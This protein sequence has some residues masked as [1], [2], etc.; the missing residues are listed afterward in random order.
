MKL[1]GREGTLDASPFSFRVTV[2][3]V[4]SVYGVERLEV[5][6]VAG[7]GSAWV[8]ADRVKVDA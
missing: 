8:N 2:T 4:K 3:D 1:I 7:T 6:P 5:S